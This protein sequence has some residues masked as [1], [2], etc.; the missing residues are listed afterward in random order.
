MAGAEED[1]TPTIGVAFY[2]NRTQNGR[3]FLI[4]PYLEPPK[5]TDYRLILLALVSPKAALR[6]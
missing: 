3:S 1:L 4:H 2:N 5:L 6:Y